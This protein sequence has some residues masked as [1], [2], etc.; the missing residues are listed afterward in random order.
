MATF[1]QL[2]W[3]FQPQISDFL[4][5]IINVDYLWFYFA[6]ELGTCEAVVDI[7]AVVTIAV[8]A[9]GMIIVVT[10]FSCVLR[11]IIPWGL[12]LEIVGA[13][14][15]LNLLRDVD[16]CEFAMLP[17]FFSDLKNICHSKSKSGDKNLVGW[18]WIG[19]TRRAKTMFHHKFWLAEWI[20]VAACQGT[21]PSTVDRFG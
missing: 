5:V 9:I 8:G 13:S 18:W 11:I 17:I 21:I 19:P 2:R 10:R 20:W 7:D 3:N 12:G 16:C 1:S 4:V 6:L 14:D 15:L